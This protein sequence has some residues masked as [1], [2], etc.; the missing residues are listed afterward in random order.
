ME[1]P[2]E[3]GKSMWLCDLLDSS[4]PRFIAGIDLATW[5][6]TVLDPFSKGQGIGRDLSFFVLS[7]QTQQEC[8]SRRC[9]TCCQPLAKAFG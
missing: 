2:R 9:P 4:Y 1:R 6:I 8:S 5:H 3:V 7:E